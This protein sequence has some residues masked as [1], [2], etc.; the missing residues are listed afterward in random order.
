VPTKDDNNGPSLVRASL[1]PGF[2]L[3]L[4]N[5]GYVAVIAF[6]ATVA[7][8]HGA[9]A[10]SAIVPVFAVTVIATRLIGAPVPDRLG[11]ERTLRAC[12][13]AEGTGLVALALLHGSVGAL[14]ATVVLAA[15]QAL[16]VP[17]L[18]VLALRRVEPRRHGAAA[19]LFFSWFDVGLV[20]RAL[21]PA[22]AIGIAGAAVLAV[23]PAVVPPAAL[24]RHRS[25]R[26]NA[27][28]GQ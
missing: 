2:G 14:G 15:G 18:G 28:V 4:V 12:V 3:A 9:A 10:A 13:T 22:A 24:A 5:V 8:D 19:G 20:A 17:A 1:R 11:A 26:Y 27:A 6:G 23:W 7:G 21:T 16:A 25:R